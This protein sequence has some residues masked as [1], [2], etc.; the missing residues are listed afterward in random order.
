MV[1]TQTKRR[2]NMKD[3]E[4]ICVHYKCENHPCAKRNILIH[5]RKECQTC[6]LYNPRKGAIPAR[7]NLKRENKY[8]MNKYNKNWD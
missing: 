2:K 3:R 5:F 1:D 8:K 7:K 6:S 4:I